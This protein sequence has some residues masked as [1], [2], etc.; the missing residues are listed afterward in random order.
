MPWRPQVKRA[1]VAVR[2]PINVAPCL[3]SRDPVGVGRADLRCAG[4]AGSDQ[5]KP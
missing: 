3:V 2:D 4:L 1:E 5:A